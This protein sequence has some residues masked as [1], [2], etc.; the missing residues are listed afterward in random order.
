[1]FARRERF[2]GP[3]VLLVLT[4][5]VNWKI[6]L[7]GQYAAFDSPD[8]AYQVAP[9]MQVQAV[10]LHK[11]HWPLLWDPYIMAG[12]P[13]LGQAQPG[14]VF[15]L[16]WLLFAAPLQHGF[17]RTSA[18]HIYMALI[19]FIAALAMYKLCRDLK[20]S[21]AASIFASVAFAFAGYV[22]TTGWPQMLNGAILAPLVL[23]FSLRAIRG[24]RA[25]LNAAISGGLL[26]LSWL[27]GHHQIP[28]YVS[29]AISAVWIF[30][31]LRKQTTNA[32]VA[33]TGLFV[34]LMIVMF[35]AGAA[36]TLPAY[37]YGADVV[38]WVGA[39]HELGWKDNV[40]YSVHETFSL[41]PA[42]VLGIFIQGIHTNTDPFIGLTVFLLGLSGVALAWKNAVVRILLGLA[43]GGLLYAFAGFTLLHGVI[44]AML[45]FVE[46]A[47]SAGM[48]VFIFHLGICTLSAF[49]LDAVLNHGVLRGPWA[50]RITIASTGVALLLWLFLFAV[51][52]AKLPSEIRPASVAM[53]GLAA[54]FIICILQ[55]AK[56]SADGPAIQLKT[57]AVL[58]IGVMMLEVGTLAFRD[59]ANKDGEQKFWSSLWRDA[60]VAR[61]LKSR[62]PKFRVDVNSD[63]IPYNFGDWYGIETYWGYLA[64]APVSLMR[65]MGEARTKELLG[66]Q[67]YVAKAPGRGAGRELIASP[68]SGLKVFEMANAMPR[69]WVVH[70]IVNVPRPENVN[71]HI[72]DPA[73]PFA[74]STFLLN[75]TPPAMENCS[76]DRANVELEDPEYIVVKAML[77]CRGM[78]IVGDSYSKDWVATVD[79]KRAPLYAAYTILD[80]VVADAGEHRIELRYRPVSFY[81]GASLSAASLLVIFAVWWFTRRRT[82]LAEPVRN[83]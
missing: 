43:I 68:T 82:L 81:L 46:K 65:I 22:G 26:G 79:G 40:P 59:L 74:Q 67:Y 8:F 50:K 76:G 64:S 39:S 18:I 4:I 57:A 23:M 17:I 73:L 3:L 70:D 58:L 56:P 29:L 1:M 10:E 25:L 45:P 41:Q 53:T 28:I 2:I 24:E 51:Y 21:R 35:M 80:G 52:A 12:H 60:D 69:T 32:R 54:V 36:Q 14:V 9:W 33:K 42:S 44:Y 37:S 72:S 75:Q 27:S 83:W 66:V 71:P 30:E 16:N 13:L 61:F 48:A 77:N 63:D 15:P 20:R 7:T 38:R 49:G 11:H 47:R 55:A 31:I 34:A 5:G 78:V 19:R 62:P 6:L